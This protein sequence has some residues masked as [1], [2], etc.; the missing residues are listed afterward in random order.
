MG[1]VYYNKNKSIFNN[2]LFIND[3]EE[4]IEKDEYMNELKI[5]KIQNAINLMD[6]KKNKLFIYFDAVCNL[7]TEL[8]FQDVKIKIDKVQIF[9]Q[10]NFKSLDLF[11]LKTHIF[12]IFSTFK[13]FIDV[14][15]AIF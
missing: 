7:N 5:I 6:Y 9:D 11:E 1:Y 15:I 2:S 14:R 3:Y 12:S 8:K 4:Y 10:V 13:N